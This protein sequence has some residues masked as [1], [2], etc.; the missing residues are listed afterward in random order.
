[1]AICDLCDREMTTAA[2]CTVDVLHMAGTPFVVFEHG[3]DPGWGRAT[4]RCHDCGVLP[5]GFH[6][7]GC[8]VQRC[9]SCRDQLISCGCRWDELASEYDD[10]PSNDDL[11]LLDVSAP[12]APLGAG[13]LD[14][15]GPVRWVPF[16]AAAAPMRAQHHGTLRE[17]AAWALDQGRPC[18]LDAAALCLD[19]LERYRT[20]KGHRL[21]RPTVNSVLWGE[22]P[23]AA[24]PLTTVL[25]EGWHLHLWSVLVWLHISG[26]LSPDGD[27]LVALLEPLGCYGGLGADGYPMPAGTDVDFP[28]QCY[29]PHDPT[30]PPGLAQ[31]IVGHDPRTQRNL[32]VCGHIRPRSEDATL[33][34]FQPLFT[35][36]KRL[37]EKDSVVEVHP[38]E[39]SYVG[40]IDGERSTPQLWLYRHVAAGGRGR[41]DL[42]L[43]SDGNPWS[44]RADRRRRSGFRWVAVDDRSGVLR[45]ST[46]C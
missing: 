27:P 12:V 35:L 29:L 22:V 28:C 11:G 10:D 25:P 4:G 5:K 33:S 31:Y 15:E 24:V 21:D 19:V 45:A 30:C 18:D 44:P 26:R 2:S 32:V 14:V 46:A 7:V 13:G 37:R 1:M 17:I 9:P 20:P 40:V 38:D 16:R 8:D 43:D 3:R 42:F 6:H 36:S 34:S 39:F 41:D 23:N